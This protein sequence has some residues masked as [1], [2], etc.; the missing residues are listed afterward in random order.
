MQRGWNVADSRPA[1]LPRG[2]EQRPRRKHACYRPLELAAQHEGHG[3]RRIVQ[4]FPHTGKKVTGERR[5]QFRLRRNRERRAEGVGIRREG[6]GP[7]P[8]VR[9]RDGEGLCGRAPDRAHECHGEHG[10]RHERDQHL[11]QGVAIEKSIPVI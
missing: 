7:S 8:E 11:E 4:G 1:S 10:H 9:S 5:H 3:W 6:Q 2:V